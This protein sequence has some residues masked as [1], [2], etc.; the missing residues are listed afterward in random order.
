MQAGKSRILYFVPEFSLSQ[1][2]YLRSQVLAPA[3]FLAK[4]GFDCMFIGA[5]VSEKIAAEAQK[6]MSRCYGIQS[7]VCGC[8]SN[9]ISFLS[10][11]LTVRRV[12]WRTKRIIRD[13][14]PT[15][16]YTRG[17]FSPSLAR[18]IAK[19]YNAVHVHDV[20]GI[21][22]E[23][24]VLMGGKKGI[25]HFFLHKKDLDVIRKADRLS[26]VSTGL[27]NWINKKTNRDD[28]TVIPCCADVD[29]FFP[30][31]K[32]RSEIRKHY[33]IADKEQ[34]IC[35]LGGL[36]Y[37]KIITTLNFFSWLHIRINLRK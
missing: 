19:R 21:A 18:R 33:H 29:K 32:Y 20:R 34:V 11:F 2:Q 36:S 4:E 25:R 13:F 3:S 26:C 14:R 35:Y 27:K 9:K 23:E 31:N 28:V 24:W 6:N 16:I 37:Q 8:Y 7:E 15:H 1:A 10:H 12:F 5:D 22:A 17:F 30:N